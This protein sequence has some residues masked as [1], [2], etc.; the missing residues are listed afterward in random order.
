MLPSIFFVRY[1]LNDKF[2]ALEFIVTYFKLCFITNITCILFLIRYYT[3]SAFSVK[4]NFIVKY[5]LLALL[6][7][8]ILVI[9]YKVIS[10]FI[11]VK[12]ET[13]RSSKKNE[14]N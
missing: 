10:N 13:K 4:I 8:F 11:Q 5:S 7:N 14:K 2:T 9:A 12:I 1:Y 3:I 6:I